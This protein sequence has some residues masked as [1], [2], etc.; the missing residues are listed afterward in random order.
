MKVIFEYETFHKRTEDSF[1]QIYL[2]YEI[3]IFSLKTA[4]LTTF[5]LKTFFFLILQQ[6]SIAPPPFIV[7]NDRTHFF[8][9]LIYLLKNSKKKKP[10]FEEQKLKTANKNFEDL[11]IIAKQTEV[12]MICL[13]KW[14]CGACKTF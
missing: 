10:E 1:V 14:L 2:L 9:D 4:S 6:I 11:L 12:R 7:G 13:S 3:F 8:L 5:T